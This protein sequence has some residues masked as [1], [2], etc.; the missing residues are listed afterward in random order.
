MKHQVVALR[1][2]PGEVA[3]DGEKIKMKL[4]EGCSGL[5]F[6]FESKKSARKYWGK[7]VRMVRVGLEKEN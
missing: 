7:D 6:I 3:V 1:Q 4:P 2:H 5:M